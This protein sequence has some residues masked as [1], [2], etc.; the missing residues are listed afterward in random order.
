MPVVVILNICLDNIGKNM[1]PSKWES[2]GLQQLH[3]KVVG[4]RQGLKV[5][6]PFL[7]AAKY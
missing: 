1:P 2:L 4:V 5:I 7:C 6:D 3:V